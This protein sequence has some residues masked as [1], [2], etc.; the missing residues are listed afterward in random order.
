MKLSIL[1]ILLVLEIR[2]VLDEYPMDE[3]R[4][5][6]AYPGVLAHKLVEHVEEHIRTALTN[7]VLRDLDREASRAS[8]IINDVYCQVM[9]DGLVKVITGETK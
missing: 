4:N 9:R 7:D 6:L 2:K 5:M 1:G 8:L 3:D